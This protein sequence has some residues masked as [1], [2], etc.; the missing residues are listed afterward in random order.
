MRQHTVG[1]MSR[2][3]RI[4][5]EHTGIRR[6]HGPVGDPGGPGAN[7]QRI[8]GKSLCLIGKST[9]YMEMKSMG[10]SMFPRKINV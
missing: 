8:Y 10:K 5:R 9:I 1:D 4:P 6:H 7:I 2:R 3:G